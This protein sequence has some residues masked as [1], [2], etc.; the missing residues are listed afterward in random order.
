MRNITKFCLLSSVF[1]FTVVAA[2]AQSF[3]IGK[4]QPPSNH[5]GIYHGV[6]DIINQTNTDK[7]IHVKAFL[8]GKNND[9]ITYFC[10][11]SQCYSPATIEVDYPLAA[12]ATD[13]LISYL[14]PGGIDGTSI[15]R[16]E[17]SD[18][19]NPSDKIEYAFTFIVG[20]TSVGEIIHEAVGLSTAAPNPSYDAT[21]IQY[22]IPESAQ[23]SIHLFD[24]GLK[25]LKTFDISSA[26]TSLVIPTAEFASGSYFYTLVVNGKSVATNKLIIA[27]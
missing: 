6:V 19:N 27:R 23:G 22:T 8:E 21:T 11:G 20:T 10:T 1:C 4:V 16:Y 12:N 5:D 14:E 25:L 13:S 7:T 24:A 26:N 9:H 15:I 3:K 17:F 18:V 2:S